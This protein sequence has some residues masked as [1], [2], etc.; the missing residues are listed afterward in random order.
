[1]TADR[2]PMDLGQLTANVMSRLRNIVAGDGPDKGCPKSWARFLVRRGIQK[3]PCAIIARA[4]AKLAGSTLA[5]WSRTPTPL[6]LPSVTIVD[7]FDV[8][9]A[10][11]PP[12]EVFPI[13]EIRV[14]QCEAWSDHSTIS[15][16]ESA[17]ALLSW[18]FPNVTEFGSVGFHSAEAVADFTSDVAAVT[19]I[20]LLRVEV[21][22]TCISWTDTGSTFANTVSHAFPG[23]RT[24]Q[25]EKG[26]G[27]H[28][29][30][31]AFEKVKDNLKG[32]GKIRSD[33]EGI[34]EKEHEHM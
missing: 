1:M 23:L 12:L 3:E 29:W 33:V 2:I 30:T 31:K 10:L 16:S 14:L 6:T 26:Q 27:L 18:R 32:K 7:I 34:S 22:P 28:S 17:V 15:L 19:R 9:G 24:C 21:P 8:E 20:K 25:L 13:F 5:Y 11:N 4:W